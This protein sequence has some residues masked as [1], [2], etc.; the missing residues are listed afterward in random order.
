MV[1]DILGDIGLI[2]SKNI[3]GA[4]IT[5]IQKLLAKG[6]KKIF[7]K[8]RCEDTYRTLNTVW[9]S[10]FK[11]DNYSNYF[12]A[13]ENGKFFL[14]DITKVF[15]NSRYS[16]DRLNLTNTLKKEDSKLNQKTI[17]IVGS[18]ISTYSIYLWP[19]FKIIKEFEI[20]PEAYRY[21]EINKILNK[22]ENIES[23]NMKYQKTTCADYLLSVVPA[24]S[25]D[26]HKEYFFKDTLIVYFTSKDTEISKH[27]QELKVHYDCKSSN[28]LSVRP[29]AKGINTYRIVL[30]K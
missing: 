29:Y 27:V 12:Y 3:E 1:Y 6:Y 11:K 20:N 9:C 25:L 18:G 13:K 28:Y 5:E 16:S 15:Y 4:N 14:G 21:G 8:S 24:E 22:A 19:L 23:F 2:T 10:P 17:V 30:K 26:F 7:K